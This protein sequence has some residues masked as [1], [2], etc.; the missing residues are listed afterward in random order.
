MSF[1]SFPLLE[2]YRQGVRAWH[3]RNLVRTIHKGDF[4]KTQSLLRKN[5]HLTAFKESLKSTSSAIALMVLERMSHDEINQRDE[6]GYTPLH[7]AVFHDNPFLLERLLKKGADAELEN[8]FGLPPLFYAVKK[9]KH[10][11]LEKLLHYGAR[12]DTIWPAWRVG[13]LHLAVSQGDERSVQLLLQYGADVNGL[14]ES[15]RTPLHEACW[16]ENVAM[17][18]LL[19]KEGALLNVV[20]YGGRTALHEACFR[21]RQD[22]IERMVWHGVPLHTKDRVGR[23]TRRWLQVMDGWEE[24]LKKVAIEGQRARLGERL[25]KKTE[26]ESRKD[27][28][29]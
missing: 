16:A 4:P 13:P 2:T 19:A 1:L 18:D 14:T 23:D 17:I 20:C 15:G 21:R 5:F 24:R 26:H 10:D 3:R 7:L 28:R 27:R 22:C 6:K 25:K 9:S 12:T 11:C 8:D 29:M